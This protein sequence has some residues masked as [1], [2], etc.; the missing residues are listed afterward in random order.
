M[1]VFIGPMNPEKESG[2]EGNKL[3]ATC[4]FIVSVLGALYVLVE[5]GL[6]VFGR[7]ICVSGGC[8]LVAQLA[9]FGD[10]SLIGI[11]LAALAFLAL[12][13]GLNRRR[14]NALLDSAINLVLIAA[15]AAEGFLVGYQVFWLTE[16]CLLC[17][18]VFGFLVLLGLLRLLAGWKEAAAGFAALAAV[19]C[20]V[21]L[22]LPPRGTALP[23]DKKMILFYSPDCPHCSEIK[24]E[25]DKNKLDI[26]PVPVKE[27]TATLKNL[28]VDSVP[29]LF[30]NGRYEKLILNG[31]EAIRRYLAACHSSGSAT[32]SLPGSPTIMR[33]SGKKSG[34][35]GSL[36]PVAPLSPWGTSDQLFNPAPDEGVCKEEQK[37]K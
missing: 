31:K 35:P 2:R 34:A 36:L 29:T 6:Q 17:L 20:V 13:S 9:R 28:G 25:I 10:L 7:S 37:C 30:V 16:L 24:E 27:Y 3:S 15:L 4:F 14:R 33:E 22:V 11:G 12:L 32:P 26:T 19:L 5:A 18:S 8:G 23:A 1:E 21:G